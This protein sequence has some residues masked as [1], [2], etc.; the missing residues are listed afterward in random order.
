[1]KIK[2][3]ENDISDA[4]QAGNWYSK[5]SLMISTTGETGTEGTYG[6]NKVFS[7]YQP[8]E[9]VNNHRFRDHP[10]PHHQGHNVTM[11]PA[12]PT[13]VPPKGHVRSDRLVTW[14]VYMW[15]GLDT[16]HQ[17]LLAWQDH[18]QT[19]GNAYKIFIRKCEGK[20]PLQTLR[21]RWA[22]LEWVLLSCAP[23]ST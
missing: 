23:R 6:S 14:D 20:K 18:T 15:A 13:Y 1:M 4:A 10:C 3:L 11:C 21:H 16:V 5:T 9:L 12:R 19:D 22:I 2:I 8:C 7:S 17:I